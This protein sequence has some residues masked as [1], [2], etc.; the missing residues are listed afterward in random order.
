MNKFAALALAALTLSLSSW[1][2]SAS[3]EENPNAISLELSAL[4]NLYYSS[5]LGAAAQSTFYYGGGLRFSHDVASG[6]L[7]DRAS[8][9]D[10][11]SLDVGVYYYQVA[12][13]LSAGDRYTVVPIVATARYSVRLLRNFEPFVYGGM[14]RNFSTGPLGNSQAAVGAG[15]FL[16][17]GDMVSVRTDVG[18][19]QIGAGVAVFF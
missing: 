14:L 16:R 13:F 10:A 17:L 6:L 3:S 15:A 8:A 2:A 9:T 11:L 12:D 1:C 18:T 7:L 4:N 19:D 5:V